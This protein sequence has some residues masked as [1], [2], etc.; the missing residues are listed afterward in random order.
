[1]SQKILITGTNSGFGRLASLALA[2]K[3]H[4]VFGTM[5][6]IAGRNR[7]SA[8]ELRAIASQE[9]LQLHVVE[10][11]LTS[12]ESVNSGVKEILSRAGTLDV[13]VNNAGY[14]LLGV[15]ETLTSEQLLEQLDV[16]VVAPHR[17]M[18][19]VLPTLRGRGKGLVINISSGLG[20]VVFPL[21]G[22]YAA[23][24]AALE[25]LSDAYRY[26]LK[27]TGVDVTI[28][29][30]GAHPTDFHSRLSVGKDAERAQGYGPFANGVEMMAGALRQMT[31]GPGAQD[32]QAV[33]KAILDLVEA[34]AGSRPSRVVVDVQ[35]GHNGIQQFHGLSLR[36][37]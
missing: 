15:E 5:R 21:M 11:E 4:T 2:R 37:R 13:V 31:D 19:A 8:E 10:M 20:R 27:A 34:P 6:D 30:P 29:Q 32:P 16:N 35:T 24:K 36:R 33:V 28:L 17:V 26:E 14:S 7:A 25:A 23:S 9:G 18:R 3:G 1:M 22:A 12:D